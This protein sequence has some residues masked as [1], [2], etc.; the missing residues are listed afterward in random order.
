MHLTLERFKAPGSGEGVGICGH[1]LGD[2][3]GRDGMRNSQGAEQ[4]SDNDWTVKRKINNNKK[5]ENYL[6]ARN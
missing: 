3:G 2:E 6:V 4:D 5:K 1:P